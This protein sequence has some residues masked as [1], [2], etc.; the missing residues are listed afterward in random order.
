ML[1]HTREGLFA[2]PA[3]GGNHN[4]SGWDLIG[5]TGIRLLWTAEDQTL[6]VLPAPEHGSVTQWGGGES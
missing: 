6:D 2:D 4:F 5:Y 3:Y 1:Q